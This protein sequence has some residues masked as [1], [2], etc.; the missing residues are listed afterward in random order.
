MINTPKEKMAPITPFSADIIIQKMAEKFE[1]DIELATEAALQEIMLQGT[2]QDWITS[3]LKSAVRQDIC[4]HRHKI[5][6]SIATDKGHFYHHRKVN[7]PLE[8]AE[9]TYSSYSYPMLGRTIGTLRYSDLI[10][11]KKK[12]LSQAKGHTQRAELITV[13][14]SL[15]PTDDSATVADTIPEPK[16]RKIIQSSTG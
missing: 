13:L 4:E 12:E 14:L 16:L 9:M 3:H 1:N 11:A 10:R 15:V 8:V 7:V 2:D 6:V 5:A